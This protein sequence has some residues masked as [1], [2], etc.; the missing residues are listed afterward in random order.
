MKK[1]LV[2]EIIIKN[3]SENKNKNR[4]VTLKYLDYASIEYETYLFSSSI[5]IKNLLTLNPAHV[6][7]ISYRGTTLFIQ[8]YNFVISVDMLHNYVTFID[9]NLSKIRW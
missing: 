5:T 7:K 9:E 4:N 6:S 3:Q 8:I 1:K 2:P